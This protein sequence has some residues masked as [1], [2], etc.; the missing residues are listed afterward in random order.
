M[1]K[2]TAT[3]SIKFNQPL[4]SMYLAGVRFFA[5][6]TGATPDPDKLEAWIIKYATKITVK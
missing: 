1:V 2:R 3:I 4:I 5:S 6:I